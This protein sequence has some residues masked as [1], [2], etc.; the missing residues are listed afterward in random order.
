MR[1]WMA[2][3]CSPPP[4]AKSRSIR[5]SALPNSACLPPMS[6]PV[7][8]RAAS[9][10][11]RHCPSPAHC[12]PGRIGILNRDRDRCGCRRRDRLRLGGI[13]RMMI[14]AMTPALQRRRHFVEADR[15]A[16]VLV[17]LRQDVV[18]LREVGAAGAERVSKFRYADLA[19]IISIEL[20][21]QV[22]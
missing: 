22:L 12:R 11:P 14:A 21:E 10:R 4:R 3:C 16:A 7:R 5:W 15:A 13:T 19:V 6:C 2:T 17:Q 9:M 1:R 18:G 20:R 8:L